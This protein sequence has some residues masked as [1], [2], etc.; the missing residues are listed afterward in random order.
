MTSRS[1]GFGLALLE[2]MSAGCIPIAYDIRYGPR[3]LIDHGRNGFLIRSGHVMGLARAI[4]RLQRLPRERIAD[5]RTAARR[6]AERYTDDSV[7]EQWAAELTAAR[8]RNWSRVGRD[9]PG[10]AGTA[11]VYLPASHTIT[12]P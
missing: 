3:D 6:T 1:E 9:N 7:L 11:P 5:M 4:L 12:F 8:E 10:N 2:A